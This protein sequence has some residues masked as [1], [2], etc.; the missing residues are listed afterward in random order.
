M[1]IQITITDDHMNR[2]IPY[3]MTESPVN[4]ALTGTT[5]R[6]YLVASDHAIVPGD[7]SSGRRFDE[8][9][10]SFLHNFDIGNRS[11][12]ELGVYEF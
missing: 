10:R 6:R 7:F 8:R 3:S 11:A 1:T 12:C 9:L 5:G 2:G 4:F